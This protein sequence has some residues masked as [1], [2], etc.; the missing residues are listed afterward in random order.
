M[1][2]LWEKLDKFDIIFKP[3]THLSSFHGEGIRS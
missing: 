2:M 3:L 1:K